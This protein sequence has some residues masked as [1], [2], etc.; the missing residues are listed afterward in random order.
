MIGAYTSL[1]LQ[2]KPWGLGPRRPMDPLV[3]WAHGVKG[4]ARTFPDSVGLG[5]LVLA[6]WD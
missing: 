6:L 5:G 4:R 3:L 2:T 1:G